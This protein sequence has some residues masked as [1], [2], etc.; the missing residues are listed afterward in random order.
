MTTCA[1][2][3]QPATASVHPSPE[4]CMEALAGKI[5]GLEAQIAGLEA[6]IA[7][8]ESRTLPL[9]RFGAGTRTNG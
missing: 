3:G 7:A 2:C 8:M 4:R 6:Q 5:A 9:V 1:I